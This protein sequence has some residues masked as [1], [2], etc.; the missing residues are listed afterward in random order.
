MH[1]CAVSCSVVAQR[2]RPGLRIS[3][4]LRFYHTV[5]RAVNHEEGKAGARGEERSRY[6]S[7]GKTSGFTAVGISWRAELARSPAKAPIFAALREEHILSPALGGLSAGALRCIEHL[8]RHATYRK[9]AGVKRRVSSAPSLNGMSNSDQNHDC[10]ATPT[11]RLRSTPLALAIPAQL[12]HRGATRLLLVGW[13][14][15]LGLP[16]TL[17]LIACAQ[18]G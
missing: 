15:L 16:Q 7:F 4:L 3:R 1:L 10:R 17:F 18:M 11:R 9:C 5:G 13:I 12:A 14:C 8:S 2:A 6:G